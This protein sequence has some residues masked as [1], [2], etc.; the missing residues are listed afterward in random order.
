MIR[1]RYDMKAIQRI[2]SPDDPRVAAYRGVTDPELARASGVFVAE[3]RLVVRRV[4][5]DSKY[6]VQSLL[7]NDAAYRD[8]APLIDR[9]EGVGGTGTE[10]L[11]CDTS[12]FLGI[13]GV[14]FHR[15]CLALVKRPPP[16]P[17][18][19]VV[20][21]AR[22]VIALDGVG[23]PDNV[24]GIFRNAAAF[25]VDAVLIGPGCCDPFYRKAIRTSMGSVLRVPFAAADAWPATMDALRAEGLMIAALTP[26][27]PSESIDTFVTRAAGLRLALIVGAEGAG[28]TRGVETTADVRVHIP[29][30]DDVDS[31][32]VAVAVGIA[33]YALRVKATA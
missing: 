11:L 27:Q 31:L 23:N 2:T 15:G 28:L 8:L 22:C 18:H 4:L 29:I 26:R 19:D 21:G 32:N 10:V 16:A 5:E 25:G 12:D 24:G 6:C 30:V 17:L 7:L 13:S 20:A 33:L 14:N 3:G 1:R 9:T